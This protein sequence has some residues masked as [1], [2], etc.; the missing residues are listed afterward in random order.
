V[1]KTLIARDLARTQGSALQIMGSFS[2]ELGFAAR[3]ASINGVNHNV[4]TWGNRIVRGAGDTGAKWVGINAASNGVQ[5]FSTLSGASMFARNSSSAW[6]QAKTAI[7]GAGFG[8]LLGGFFAAQAGYEA[9]RSGGGILGAGSAAGKSIVTTVL[10]G[11]AIGL[12]ASNPYLLAG[13]A[14]GALTYAAFKGK[15]TGNRYLTQSRRSEMSGA[16]N[17]AMMTRQAY[18][19]RQRAKESMQHSYFNAMRSLGNEASFHHM[20]KSRY[21]NTEFYSQSKPIL[22]Y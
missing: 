10:A 2:G 15:D 17:P 3:T 13:V 21:G 12:V 6:A 11:K 8:G 7:G 1:I 9:Y 18:T 20:P 19:M 22:G 16:V 14:G 4:V 5:G